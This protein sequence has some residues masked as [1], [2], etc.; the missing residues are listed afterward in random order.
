[1]EEEEEKVAGCG[2]DSPSLKTSMLLNI[3]VYGALSGKRW[4]LD[5]IFEY[6]VRRSRRTR[7]ILRQQKII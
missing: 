2:A 7:V 1:M 4:K 3:M 5:M 6:S